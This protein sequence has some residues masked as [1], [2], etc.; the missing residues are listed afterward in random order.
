MDQNLQAVLLFQ[1]HQT[2][3]PQIAVPG[4]AGAMA[5]PVKEP[6]PAEPEPAPAPA[7]EEDN[8]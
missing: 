2:T 5:V 7:K 1:N 6:P 8:G 4:A 3:T